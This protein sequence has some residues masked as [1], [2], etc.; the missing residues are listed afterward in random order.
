M[1]N[2]QYYLHVLHIILFG[3]EQ[4]RPYRRSEIVDDILWQVHGFC[5]P[6]IFLC[7]SW[8]ICR[9][10][11]P[12]S[13]SIPP[14]WQSSPTPSSAVT[15][16]II[17]WL[18]KFKKGYFYIFNENPL[19][20]LGYENILDTLKCFNFSFV[21]VSGRL[22]LK[23]LHVYFYYLFIVYLFLIIYYKIII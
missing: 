7:F 16:L 3:C 12:V 10:H 22:N 18:W 11:K 4:P 14:F 13:P 17:M 23:Y 20:I 5:T 8:N 9:L 2:M 15:S 21:L 1:Q 6:S 19:I